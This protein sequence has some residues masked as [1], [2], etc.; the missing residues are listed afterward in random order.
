MIFDFFY[1]NKSPFR[2]CCNNIE[3]GDKTVQFEW[4]NSTETVLEFI[5]WFVIFLMF[6]AVLFM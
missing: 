6:G 5:P 1:K 4:L 2:F 3:I